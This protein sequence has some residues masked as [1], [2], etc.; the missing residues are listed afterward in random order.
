[1]AYKIQ[2]QKTAS[3]GWITVPTASTTQVQVQRCFTSTEIIR[4][5]RDG[6]PRAASSTF[7]QLLSFAWASASSMLLYVHG[8]HKDYQGRGAQ[9]G[10]L[11]FHTV[12]SSEVVLFVQCCFTFT[13]TIRTI[14]DGEPRMSTSHFHTARELRV[15]P[16]NGVGRQLGIFQ[17]MEASQIRQCF[18]TWL[19]PRP[20]A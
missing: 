11:D 7:T 10:H 16:R 19:N 20:V 9:D 6:E 3:W 13:E 18:P 12:L 1:M 5:I 15:A 8:G 4:T 14:R 17:K 2:N